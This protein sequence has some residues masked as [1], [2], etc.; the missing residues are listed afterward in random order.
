MKKILSLILLLLPAQV[1]SSE[2]TYS[3]IC[4]SLICMTGEAIIHCPLKVTKPT[5]SYCNKIITTQPIKNIPLD[6]QQLTTVDFSNEEN[7]YHS[8]G[9]LIIHCKLRRL[10][11]SK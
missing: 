4:Y 1:L 5:K 7:G 9:G 2:L 3:S 11:H 8:D 10:S 6:Q